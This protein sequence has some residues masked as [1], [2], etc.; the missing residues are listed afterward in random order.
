MVASQIFIKLKVESFKLHFLLVFDVDAG[1]FM[2]FS[3]EGEESPKDSKD[4]HLE[5]GLLSHCTDH[6]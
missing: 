5:V 3:A 2:N 6:N 4:Q 1:E